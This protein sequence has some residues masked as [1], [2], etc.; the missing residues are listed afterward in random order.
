MDAKEYTVEKCVHEILK[1]EIFFKRE[2]GVTFS[3]GEPFLQSDFLIDLL[4]A[5]KEKGIHTAIETSLYTDLENV[6]KAFPYL[7]SIYKTCGK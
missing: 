5:C 4:K 6:Q 1:D 7:D 2:G 3:G